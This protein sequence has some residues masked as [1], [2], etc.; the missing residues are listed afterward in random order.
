[1]GL[2]IANLQFVWLLF[3]SVPQPDFCTRTFLHTPWV[4][5]LEETCQ[6][7]P[8]QVQFDCGT[9]YPQSCKDQS[10]LHRSLCW[11]TVMCAAHPRHAEKLTKQKCI[12]CSD[13]GQGWRFN[14]G[15]LQACLAL[16]VIGSSAVGSFVFLAQLH[17]I[18]ANI[19]NKN[20][21]TI[22]SIWSQ[23]SV[24]HLFFTLYSE[25][26]LKDGMTPHMHDWF[27]T[28]K[29]LAEEKNW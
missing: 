24:N 22:F 4:Q 9:T 1:M 12:L 16:W 28:K 17:H 20:T 23:S 11:F 26:D 21:P 7:R 18:G 27:L 2:F 6:T 10:R 29:K 14:P 19:S 5:S 13:N 15:C 25:L 3:G 8:R